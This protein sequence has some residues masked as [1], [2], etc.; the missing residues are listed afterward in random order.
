MQ[1]KN[2]R[3]L[4]CPN[5]RSHLNKRGQMKLSFGM[6]FSIILIIIFIA[7]AFYAITKF[8][9]LQDSV[10]IGQ[11]KDNLQNDIDKM[12]KGSQGTQEKSY[13]VPKKVKAICFVDDEYRNLVFESE[14]FIESEELEHLDIEK[15]LA[16]EDSLCIENIKGKVSLT[17]KKDYEDILVRIEK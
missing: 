9:E 7:F 15:T 5:R 1:I 16:G 14:H 17:L 4:I 8:L 13:V 2:Q 6:I 11:F 12:W 3:L 10:K